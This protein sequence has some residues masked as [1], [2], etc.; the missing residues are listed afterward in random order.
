ML[1]YVTKY[2]TTPPVVTV[3]GVAAGADLVIEERSGA[4]CQRLLRRGKADM[5]FLLEPFDGTMLEHEL[6]RED[7]GCI[8]MLKTHPLAQ[9]TGPVPFAALKGLVEKP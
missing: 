9:E 7:F 3:T 1:L 2:H 6:I 5:A 4:D 8:A